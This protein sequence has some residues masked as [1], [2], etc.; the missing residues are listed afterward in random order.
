MMKDEKR[1]LYAC[2]SSLNVCKLMVLG[3]DVTHTH[4]KSLPELQCVLRLWT[5]TVIWTMTSMITA[6]HFHLLSLLPHTHSADRDELHIHRTEG[7]TLPERRYD[8]L[9]CNS[10]HYCLACHIQIKFSKDN[11]KKKKGF[12]LISSLCPP[13]SH[14][15][16]GLA[17]AADD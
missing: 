12:F 9:T 1:N 4:T 13:L 15:A 17:G 6:A 7:P 14:N 3:L 5:E 16:L 11:T 8:N 2:V 10:V